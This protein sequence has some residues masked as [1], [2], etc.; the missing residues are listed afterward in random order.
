M[1]DTAGR[2][3]ASWVETYGA[4]LAGGDAVRVAELYAEDGY[5]RDIIAFT[6]GYH[7][8]AGRAA[9][10]QAYERTIAN[11]QPR[12]VRVAAGRMAP[13][14]VRRSARTVIE[15]YFDYDTKI[16]S[17]TGFVRL[18]HDDDGTTPKAWLLLTTLQE[19]RGFEERTGPRRPSGVEFSTHFAGDN[20]LDQRRHAAEYADHDPDVLIVG[21]GQ[22]GLALGARL[23]QIGVDTLIV[24]RN[25]RIGDNWR[26]RYHSLT[27]HNEV[28]A[29]SMPY[30]PFPDTW[31]T[32]LPKDKLAGWLE[33]YAEFMEL[34]VWTGTEFA[35]AERDESTRT[36]TARLRR[37]GEPERT[38]TVRHVVLATGSVSGLPKWPELP[39]LAGFA[40]EVMHSS[41]F[42]SGIP[43]AG[44][45][46]VV[47]GTGNSGHDVAQELH[48]NGAAVTIVQRSPTCVVSLVP[49]GTM[50]YSLYSEGPTEDIDL[51]TA[52]IPYPVLRE[53]YQWLTK[54]TC[55]LDRDLLDRLADAG[56]ETDF[57]H[58]GTGF[59]MKYLRQ[60]G[61]YYINVGC[62]D[63]IAEQAIDL[64]QARDIDTF[65]GGGLRL[66]DGRELPA[67]LVVLATGYENQQETVRRLFGGSVADRVGPVWGFDGEGFMRN[68]WRPTAQQ[69]FWLMGGALNDCRLYSRFLALFIKA[70]LADL[71][72]ENDLM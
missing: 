13:R 29:N 45:R 21:G 37:D 7:T 26:N 35:G 44:R 32:F 72:P 9:V 19:L 36:W 66:R 56:F 49:S 60:G 33:G 47:V 25:P 67:D 4:A 58:D 57:G 24:E 16:G 62:S 71:L 14:I 69:G 52:S 31:P 11:T 8:F 1:T 38:V 10:E 46:A 65:T 5:W 51:I 64:V 3:F 50:V 27:L 53:S 2:V 48:S 28:W 70:D 54:R 20:W 12:N 39:G 42:D 17:G 41:Q 43:Y 23:A 59:H 68:M 63:L 55:E 6:W 22:A 61:G 18:L 15:G 34:N 40:G 30:L